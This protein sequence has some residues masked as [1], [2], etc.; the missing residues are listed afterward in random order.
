MSSPRRG[1]GSAAQPATGLGNGAGNA[2]MVMDA[3][4]AGAHIVAGTDSP[5]ALTFHGEL[6]DLC[7]PA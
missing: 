4:K 7:F 5:N 2:K 1:R 3:L 6:M